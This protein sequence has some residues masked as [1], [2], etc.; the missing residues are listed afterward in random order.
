MQHI[1]QLFKFINV[2]GLLNGVNLFIKIKTKNVENLKIV[3]IKHPIYLRKSSTDLPTFYQ[4]FINNDYNIKFEENSN[5][6][7]DAGA[8]IGL[9]SIKM[10]NQFPDSKII[11]IE[12]DTENFNVLQKNLSF[13]NNIFFENNGLWHRDTKLRVYDKFN[14]GKWGIVVEEDENNGTINSLS[15]N[16]IIQKYNLEYI[17]ILKIDIE[18]SEKQ[19]FSG[20]YKN[21]IPKVKTIVIELHD[22]LEPGCSKQFFTAINECIENYELS[23]KGESIIVKNLDLLHK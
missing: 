22:R 17:D 20:N 16:S 11:C 8:N 21:W 14:K 23:F 13:Y 18:T 2:F 1:K 3:G 19:L 10:K 7:L 6:I 4:V 5:I 12:P 15:I 9:F